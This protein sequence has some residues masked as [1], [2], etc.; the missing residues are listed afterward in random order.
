[1]GLVPGRVGLPSGF[2]F[3]RIVLALHI[4]FP[5]YPFAFTC[6]FKKYSAGLSIGMPIF[7][8]ILSLLM[9]TIQNEICLPTC[10]VVFLMPLIT[11]S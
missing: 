9:I 8:S 11:V 6:L 10:S 4:H 7:I 3:F 2:F 1:M 5:K